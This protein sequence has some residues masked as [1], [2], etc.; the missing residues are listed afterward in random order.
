MLIYDI[1]PPVKLVSSSV[2]RAAIEKLNSCDIKEPMCVV[3][4]NWT[5]L[6]SLAGFR[7]I[8]VW[9]PAMFIK[10][11]NANPKTNKAD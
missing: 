3:V 1:K 11:L 9:T 2:I 10:R 4:R 8:D 5:H 6:N 7:W